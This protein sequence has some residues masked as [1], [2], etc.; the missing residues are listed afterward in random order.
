M[1]RITA[2]LAQNLNPPPALGTHPSRNAY[3]TTVDSSAGDMADPNISTTL[4]QVSAQNDAW[5]ASLPESQKTFE[6]LKEIGEIN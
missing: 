1:P 3:Q 5:F 6:Y 4:N 2:D